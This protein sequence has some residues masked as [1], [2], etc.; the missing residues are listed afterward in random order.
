MPPTETLSQLET[1]VLS[2][3]R[4]EVLQTPP[5]FSVASDLFE[6]GLD[7]MAI[8]QLLLL[9][10]EHY[11]VAIPVGSV[12]RANFKNAKA[13]AALLVAQGYAVAESTEPE[14]TAEES[15]VVS[16]AAVSAPAA[17]TPAALQAPFDRLPLRDCDFFTHAF[18]EMLR[19]AGQGGHIAHSFI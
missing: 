5:D 19:K 2:L 15:P 3:V 8:M 9:L 18:D 12:S 14:P 16:P 17:V 11:G 10:E 6:A 7:S 13:I 1:R 4:D